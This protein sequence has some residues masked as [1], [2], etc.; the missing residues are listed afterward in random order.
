MISRY[1]SQSSPCSLRSPN[2]GGTAH[3]SALRKLPEEPALRG[4][5][6]TGAPTRV[7]GASEGKARATPPSCF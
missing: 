2:D 1:P 3:D 5:E 4:A 6:G 7:A